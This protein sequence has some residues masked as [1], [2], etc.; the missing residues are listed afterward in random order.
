[1]SSSFIFRPHIYD[2]NT[3]T[4]PDVLIDDV[5]VA[6]SDG[7][8]LSISRITNDRLTTASEIQVLGDD[9]IAQAAILLIAA[10]AGMLIGIASN[11]K[12]IYQENPQL[13]SK[14]ISRQVWRF[15]HVADHW[16]SLLVRL[17]GEKGEI[18]EIGKLAEF[19]PIEEIITLIASNQSSLD[20]GTAVLCVGLPILKSAKPSSSYSLK[21]SDQEKDQVLELNYQVRPI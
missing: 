16:E 20:K 8:N 5:Y 21:L 7:T 2:G 12:S 1:M 10:G 19:A 11:H 4:T 17:T 6:D 14:P 9:T 18:I 3:V 15:Q 13:F